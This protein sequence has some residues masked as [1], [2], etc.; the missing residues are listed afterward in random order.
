MKIICKNGDWKMTIFDK[1]LNRIAVIGNYLPRKCGIAT[2]TTDLCEAIALEFPDKAVFAL[3]MNDTPEGYA[4]PSMVKFELHQEE[5]ASYR[6]A[7]D[8]LNIN[9]VN[10]VSLQHEYGIFGGPYGSYVLSLLKELRTPLVTTLHTVLKDPLPE[11]KRVLEEIGQLSDRLVVMSER[12]VDFLKDIYNIPEEK[13]DFIPHGIP[14]VPFV[15][16]NFYKDKFNVEGKIVLLTFG[17]LSPNKGLETV[18]KAL[19]KVVKKYPN[20]VYIVV[21]ATHPG[22]IKHEGERYRQM[23]VNIIRELHLE[24]NVK[25]YNRFV[26]LEE[27]VQFIGAT[28]IYITPYLNRAQITSGTLAY[29]VGAGKAIVSTPYWY[30][31]ELLSD[32]RGLLAPFG[33]SDAMAERII[34]LLDNETERHAIRK[35]AYMYGRDMIWPR[36]ANLY[37]ESFNRA[38]RER[39]RSYSFHFPQKNFDQR[40]RQLPEINLDHIN[41]LTDDCGILRYSIYTVP[42]YSGGYSTDDNSRGL[43]AATLMGEALSEN[44]RESERLAYRY[45]SF[46]WNAFDM[47][48]GRFRN[49]LTYD[50]RW[51]DDMGS[52]EC[53]ARALWA[54]GLAIGRSVFPALKGPSGRL[55]LQAL[56]A[57]LDFRYPR[58]WAYTLLA[59]HEYL[60]RFYGDSTA[61]Q[62]REFLSE[63]LMNMFIKNSTQDWL[64][65]EDSVTYLNAILS[66]ALILSGRWMS[67][68]D[69][70]E[71]GYQSLRWLAE[72]Q[73]SEIGYFNPIGLE[74]RFKRGEQRKRVIQKTPETSAMVT[75]CLEVYNMTGERYWLVEARRAFDWFL[76]RNDLCTSLYD[77]ITG[78]CRNGL[79]TDR[80]DQNQGAEA[81]LSFVISLLEMYLSEQVVSRTA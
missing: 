42:D 62:V 3:P 48:T 33:D 75:A 5:I 50:K 64:W 4:Y 71:A 61:Q 36:V 13:I 1:N 21:G 25:F 73:K 70:T 14:D 8:F 43:V 49:Y 80:A 57:T 6:R 58:P 40:P 51:L 69:M 81:T 68:T 76:G 41:R 24:Q 38:K 18:I 31:E 77:P 7:S 32:N 47:D 45:L 53:H 55:F 15:D 39:T 74:E 35:R 60:R 54:L 26:S 10:V 63:K 23:L 59:V 29:T 28:D 16:P 19:P 44:N 20:L 27:L 78:G 66:H 56:P 79:H 72:I 17:L 30:A 46:L 12:G 2:F 34:Y 67:R 37:M 65:F 22:V 11:Q 52:E 9:N